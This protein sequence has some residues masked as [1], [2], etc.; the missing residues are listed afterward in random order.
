M[1]GDYDFETKS[2]G[3]SGASGKKAP[4][5]IPQHNQNISRPSLLLVVPH[6]VKCLVLFSLPHVSVV[7]TDHSL[8]SG[9]ERFQ[10]G[11]SNI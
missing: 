10:M 5:Y 9:L 11:G 3:L 1:S 2:M 6:R 7:R 4:Y 8:E